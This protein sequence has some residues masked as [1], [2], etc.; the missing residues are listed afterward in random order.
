MVALGRIRGMSSVVM[1]APRKSQ[2]PN[3]RET[4]LVCLPCQPRPAA[5]ASG[6]SIS[7]AV[8]TKTLSAQPVS[9]A[10]QRPTAFSRALMTSW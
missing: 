9:S 10:S 4:R 6:F 8:S 2:E 7:G 1:M 3:P 5:A